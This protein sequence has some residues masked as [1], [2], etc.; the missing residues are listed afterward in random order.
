M[1]CPYCAGLGPAML[2]PFQGPPGPAGERGP[3]GEDAGFG[4]L[5][6]ADMQIDPEDYFAAGGRQQLIFTPNPAQTQNFLRDP[7][8]GVT[9]TGNRIVPR[10]D[11]YGDWQDIIVN[12]LVVP[13][14]A[15]GSIIADLDVGVG[16][17][18]VPVQSGFY[19]LR[20]SGAP[21]RATFRLG[22]QTLDG[23][24]NNGAR[25]FLTGTVPFVVQS[26]SVVYLPI[27]K[28]SGRP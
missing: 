2:A 24:L 13:Q 3:A 5:R 18:A 10:P 23:F 11:G 4:Q 15:G 7:F 25:V 28:G 22:T 12:L 14:F 8:K 9:W 20:G 27:S 17:A 21:E 19:G 1:T 6:V 16:S 26:E